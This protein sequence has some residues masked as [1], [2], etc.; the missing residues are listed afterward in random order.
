VRN[1]AYC[2]GCNTLIESKHRHDFVRCPC[3]AVFVDGG[4]DYLRRGWDQA[5]PV[6]LDA[7]EFLPEAPKEWP[8]SGVWHYLKP[9]G[10]LLCGS[11]GKY[12]PYRG[13][14]DHCDSVCKHCERIQYKRDVQAVLDGIKGE[15]P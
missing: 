5:T 10:G 9:G 6:V 12:S 1:A 4:Q 3:G 15:Q 2:L 7:G 14:G 13:L 11:K 8:G